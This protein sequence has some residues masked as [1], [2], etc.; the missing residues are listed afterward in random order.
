MVRRSVLRIGRLKLKTGQSHLPRLMLEFVVRP[1]T[2]LNKWAL[3]AVVSER[4][5]YTHQLSLSQL[6]SFYYDQAT[7]FHCMSSRCMFS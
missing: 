5:G 7:L 1:F 6:C 4:E 2:T 3:V